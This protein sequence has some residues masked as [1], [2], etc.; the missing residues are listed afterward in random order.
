MVAY[1]PLALW[2]FAAAWT[3][4]VGAVCAVRGRLLSGERR[5]EVPLVSWNVVAA[6][7]LST[8]FV[9]MPFM[10]F[11]LIQNEIPTQM[12]TFYERHLMPG[13][14]IALVLVAVAWTLMFMQ[15]KRAE[16]TQ[17]DLALRRHIR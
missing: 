9:A 11:I 5:P 10:V 7:A 6:Q 3:I 15:A 1:L 4:G 12:R 2:L 14:V 16:R 17:A 13:V 8:V